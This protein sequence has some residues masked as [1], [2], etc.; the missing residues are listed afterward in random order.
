MPHVLLIEDEA[1]IA[2]AVLYALRSD[3]FEATHCLL[4]KT[5]LERLA[6][7]GIDLVV[8]DVGLPDRNGF[9][10]CRDLRRG[11]DVPVI[12]LTA[13]SSEVDRVVGFE[14]GADDYVV[15]PF[16]P[17]ELIARVRARLRRSPQR[18]TATSPSTD[19]TVPGEWKRCG[20]FEHDP[21]GRRIRYDGQSLALTRYEYGVLRT[22]LARPGAIFSR[23]QLM[24][25]V[26][27]DAADSADRTV[28][29]HIKTLRAKLHAIRSDI[30]PLRTHRG[31]G[32]SLEPMP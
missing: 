19:T 2:D 24:D 26:W 25:A 32:Y 15:K 29:A 27:T 21:S 11:N 22:L 5:G 14:L 23:A 13:R 18:D 12:F 28:D 3:G 17:R 30:D 31:I 9:E 1:G 4:G 7:G 10:V 8:L 16:S 6:Q 20:N